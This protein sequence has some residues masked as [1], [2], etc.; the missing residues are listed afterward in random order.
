[1][2][3]ALDERPRRAVL[4]RGRYL[5]AEPAAT[6]VASVL[7]SSTPHWS[8]ESMPR[9]T[10]VEGDK[11]A[12]RLRCQALVAEGVARPVAG[13]DAVRHEALDLGLR[14]ATG[15]HLGPDLGGAPAAHQG[16]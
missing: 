2:P 9:T 15:A 4:V 10:P 12:E 3:I 6:S 7:P 13:T 5:P 14:D 11:R 16:L 1:M 8:K